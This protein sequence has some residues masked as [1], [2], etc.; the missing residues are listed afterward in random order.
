[1]KHAVLVILEVEGN[2]DDAGLFAL[3]RDKLAA[4]PIA[5]G[6]DVIAGDLEEVASAGMEIANSEQEIDEEDD[7]A[8]D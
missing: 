8:D 6:D 3:A 7:D 5:L 1:M 4:P 2:I